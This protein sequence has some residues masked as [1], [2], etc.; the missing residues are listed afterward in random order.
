MKH[1]PNILSCL[2]IL[3]IPFFVWQM[4]AGNTINAGAILI[5]SG[6]TDLLDGLLARRFNWV[7]SVGKVLDPIADKIT[8]ATISIVLAILLRQYWIFFAILIVKDLVMLI[9]GGYL[10]KNG[11]KIEGARWFG[12]VV[13]VLFYAVMIGIVCFPEMPS[14]LITT[15]LLIVSGCAVL[16]AALYVPEFLQYRRSIGKKDTQGK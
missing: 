8:Q 2:R 12:K 9:L 7:S 16:A 13:T 4:F 6:I 10:L 15:L 5:F 3:L 11:V 1:I 14:W